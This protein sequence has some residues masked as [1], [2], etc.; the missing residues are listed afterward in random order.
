LS[1][2]FLPCGD[3]ALAVQLGDSIDRQLSDRV[4]SLHE[5]VRAAAL[6]GVLES[7]PTF[8]SLLVHYDPLVTSSAA[9]VQA[10]EDMVEDTRATPRKTR[11]WR[12]PVCYAPE[13]APDLAEVS[14]RSGLSPEQVAE[15]HAATRYHV[16]MI[17]FLP[18]YPYMG[19]V[20]PELVLPRRKDPRTRVPAGAVAIATNL[21]AIYT[22]ESP[23]GWN[24]IGTTPIRSF[25]A[26]WTPPALLAPGDG[27]VFT[28]I[29][30][31]EFGEIKAASEA[32]TY[33]VV[34]E[35]AAP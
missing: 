13:L 20:P 27:V 24:L 3:T 1:I 25:D 22:L 33:E 8:R 5:R 6:P 7:V 11:T 30:A 19:D 26:R 17:G 21:T 28:P 29:T 2:E 16:Y 31:Q 15:C 23:G 34:C 4:L 14:E 9:I 10:V 18:G 32:G 12:I 35:D